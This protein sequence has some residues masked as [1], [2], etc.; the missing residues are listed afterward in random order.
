MPVM[1]NYLFYYLIELYFTGNVFV[2][3]WE[4]LGKYFVL[5]RENG[6]SSEN[7]IFQ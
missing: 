2:I 1:Y 4:F 7:V 5:I 3:S 6:D